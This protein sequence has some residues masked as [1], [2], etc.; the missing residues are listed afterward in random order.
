[1]AAC[2]W[3]CNPAATN[4]Q[5]I[6]AI[7]QSASQYSSPDSLL[8][9]GIPNFEMACSI[10]ASLTNPNAGSGEFLDNVL[11][12]PF[13]DHF[14]F[15]FYSDTNQEYTYQVFDIAGKLLLENGGTFHPHKMTTVRIPLHVSKGIY[16]LRLITENNIFKSKLER[17]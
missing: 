3:Q 14:S 17:Q 16:F 1:M 6:E 7:K 13:D 12:N 9:Y 11:P 10:L 2:L 4:I 8:G 5:L 15:N